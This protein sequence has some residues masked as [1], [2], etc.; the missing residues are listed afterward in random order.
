MLGSDKSDALVTGFFEQWLGLRNLK[1]VDVDERAFPMWSNL[2]TEAMEKETFLFCK[3]LIREGSIHDVLTANYTFVNPRLAE[4]YG[5]DFEGENPENLY[6]KADVRR[7]K[8]IIERRLGRY[9][10]EE[11]WIRVEL[12]QQRRGL[13]T[14]ASILTLTSN[15]TRTSPVKR[16]KWVLENIIGDPPPP[17]PPGVPSLEKTEESHK[18]LTLRQQ[19]ELHRAD[20]GCASCHNVLD[21]IGL[22][23][24][25]FNTIGQWRSKDEGVEIDAR[26][27]LQ[28]GRTFNGPRELL[29]HLEADKEKVARHVVTQL[30]TYALGRGLVR[31]DQCTIDQVLNEARPGGYRFTDVIRAIVC[32]E[33]FLYRTRERPAITE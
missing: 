5:V 23:L 22:G 20:P 12:P 21:P 8:S 31:Q 6:P 15:P 11:K 32:S 16:G 28:D 1:L 17:A 2:L 4:Y 24:E 19:L 25:N 30:L 13:L 27:K 18:N 26:G 29:E 14:Q 3:N 9:K 33:P 10:N 7:R